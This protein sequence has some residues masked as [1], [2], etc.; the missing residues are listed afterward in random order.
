MNLHRSGKR[1]DWKRLSP[2]RWNSWQRLASWSSG[3]LT[4]GNMFTLLGLIAVLAGL[5][6]VTQRLYLAG[7]ILIIGGRLCDVLDGWL[8]DRTHTKSPLGEAFD[9]VADKLETAMVVVVLVLSGIAPTW[10]AFV[11]LVPQTLT[12]LLTFI[13]L[14]S[15]QVLHPIRAGKLAMAF[16]WVVLT[17]FILLQVV[18]VDLRTL[19][20][21]IAYGSL[22][23]QVLLW[24]YA[25]KSYISPSSKK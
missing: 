20:R 11:L 19:F 2:R 7:L 10:V 9:A 12:A 4:P 8:A 25:F 24:G 6:L 13:M 17:G 18:P 22:I 16:V 21:T 23:I 5:Y 1:S 15:G 3:V 14:R